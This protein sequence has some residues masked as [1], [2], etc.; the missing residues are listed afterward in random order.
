MDENNEKNE[1]CEINYNEHHTHSCECY[2]KH[3][4]LKY[5]LTALLVLLGSFLASY[6]VADWYFKHMLNPETQF[7]R[8]EKAMMK[9]ERQ[10][11]RDFDKTLDMKPDRIKSRANH[12]IRLEQDDDGYKVFVDMIPLNNNEKNVDVKTNGNVLTIKAAGIKDS[13]SKRSVMEMTQSYMFDNNVD[14]NKITKEMKG[15]TL[16]IKIPEINK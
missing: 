13:G 16:I 7:R 12:I 8:I 11:Q 3:P 2:E 5:L 9:H 14:L 15:D 10:M 6:M 1:S 4:I